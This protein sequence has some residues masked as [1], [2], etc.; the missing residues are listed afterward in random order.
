MYSSNLYRSCSK[1]YFILNILMGI[2]T[3]GVKCG[4][5][6]NLYRILVSTYIDC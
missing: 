5:L 2:T 3:Y 6:Y 4:K 1:L